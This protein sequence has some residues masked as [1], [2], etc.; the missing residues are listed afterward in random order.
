VTATLQLQTRMTE[1]RSGE[2]WLS[3]DACTAGPNGATEGQHIGWTEVRQFARLQITP[4]EFNRIELWGIR[5]EAFDLQPGVLRVEVTSHAATLMGAK[6]VPDQ[7]HALP[8]EVLLHGAQKGNQRRIGVRAGTGLKVQAGALAIPAK[9]ERGRNRQSFPIRAGVAQ[10]RRL[11]TRRPGAAHHGLLRYSA[12]VLE[13]YPGPAAPG[14]FFY[15]GPP[16]PCHSRIAASSR[17][18]DWRAGRC[19]DQFKPWRMRQTCA[20]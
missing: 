5:W 8:S 10:T 1:K 3:A 13:D 7:D 16:P 11:A 2:R 12:L 18:R 17:S 19:S 14:V 6:P 4:E 20:G 15:P 9:G